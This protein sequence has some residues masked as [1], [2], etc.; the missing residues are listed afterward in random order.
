MTMFRVWRSKADAEPE[1]VE[2]VVK[3]LAVVEAPAAEPATPEPDAVA[4]PEAPVTETSAAEA[5]PAPEPQPKMPHK[6]TAEELEA[7]KEELVQEIV[8]KVLEIDGAVVQQINTAPYDPRFPSTNQNRHCFIRYNEYY[9]CAFERG[10][11]DTRCQFYK[12]AY[13]SLCPPDW[14]DEWE[15]L[16]QQGLWFGKY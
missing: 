16:R 14:V 3:V 2:T 8:D 15:E 7:A 11:D 10:T 12:N 13:E 6:P 4:P 1:T 5:P 9:K